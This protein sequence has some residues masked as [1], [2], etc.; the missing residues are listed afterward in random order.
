MVKKQQQQQQQQKQ[1]HTFV[2]LE[3][4]QLRDIVHVLNVNTSEGRT[5]KA[6]GSSLREP[7]WSPPILCTLF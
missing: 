5:P 7:H 6:V 4:N 1:Q 3:C 2:Q